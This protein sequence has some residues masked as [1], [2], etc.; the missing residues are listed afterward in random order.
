MAAVGTQIRPSTY[1][2][3]RHVG[4]EGEGVRMGRRE[5]EGVE[6][7]IEASSPAATPLQAL[8]ASSSRPNTRWV[9][10]GGS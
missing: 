9:G 10:F 6:G 1:G 7:D 8:P 2:G 5:G 3:L 4:A